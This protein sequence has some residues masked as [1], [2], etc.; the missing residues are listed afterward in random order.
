MNDL[1]CVNRNSRAVILIKGIWR[2]A[3]GEQKPNLNFVYLYNGRMEVAKEGSYR[4]IDARL[5]DKDA[6]FESIRLNLRQLSMAIPR[7]R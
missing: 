4:L 6:Q 7:R 2:F 1:V 5:T 3:I